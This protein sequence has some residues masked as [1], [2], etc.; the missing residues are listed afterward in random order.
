MPGITSAYDPART[1]PSNASSPSKN[2]GGLHRATHSAAGG[3]DTPA[4]A[5]WPVCRLKRNQDSFR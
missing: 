1:K 3:P 4:Y 5:A 2:Q